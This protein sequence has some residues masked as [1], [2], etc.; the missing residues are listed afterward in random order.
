MA[1]SRILFDTNVLFWSG[2]DPTKLTSAASQVLAENRELLLVSPISTNELAMKANRGKLLFAAPVL[3]WIVALMA[4][5][6]ASSLPLTHIHAGLIEHLPW[7]HRDPFDRLLI[8]QALAEGVPILS[9]DVM[10][11]AYDVTR[12]W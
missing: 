12:I 11:D 7:H 4:E 1:D 10:F 9:S 2:T 6:G 5:L 3:D 8:A